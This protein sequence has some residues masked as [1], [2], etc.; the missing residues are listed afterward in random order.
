[1]PTADSI[2]G[3]KRI[4]LVEDD[5]WV[6]KMTRLRLQ[7]EGFEVVVASDGEGALARVGAAPAVHLI[8]MD[9]HLPKLD[10]FQVCERL[11][12]NPATM[13]IPIIVFTASLSHWEQLVNRCIDLGIADWIKKPFRSEE[14]LAKIRRVLQQEGDGHA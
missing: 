11:K 10:G 5:S 12:A 4:L 13:R 6:L 7:H 14:L 1:M 8:L 2:A 3:K 9:L